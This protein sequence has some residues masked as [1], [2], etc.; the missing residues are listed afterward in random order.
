MVQTESSFSK[1]SQSGPTFFLTRDKQVLKRAKLGGPP[2]AIMG[3]AAAAKFL[4][5]AD[6][7][8]FS[9]GTRTSLICPYFDWPTPFADTRNCGPLLSLF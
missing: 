4:S 1:L 7:G 9:G 5:G 6:A 8:L 2:L 3:P